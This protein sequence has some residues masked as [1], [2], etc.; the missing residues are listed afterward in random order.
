[1][2][3]C[4]TLAPSRTSVVLVGNQTTPWYCPPAPQRVRA[5]RQKLSTLLTIADLAAWSYAAVIAVQHFA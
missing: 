2:S 1:M 4:L 5:D 3:R